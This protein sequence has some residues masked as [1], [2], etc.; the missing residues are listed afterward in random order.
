M[1][2][3]QCSLASESRY[4]LLRHSVWPFT[5]VVQTCQNAAEEEYFVRCVLLERINSICEDRSF[6]L[7]GDFENQETCDFP[8]F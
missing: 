5:L 7:S 2:Y 4:V 8:K 3:V 6:V 1:G